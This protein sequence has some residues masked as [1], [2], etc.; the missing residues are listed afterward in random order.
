MTNRP[1]ILLMATMKQKLAFSKLAGKVGKSVGSAM[2]ESGYTA[3]TSNTPKKL[4]ESKGFQELLHLYA[5]NDLLVRVGLDALSATKQDPY[6]GEVSPDYAT[7]Y[8]YWRDF[9]KFHDNYPVSKTT[10][11]GTDTPIQIVVVDGTTHPDI[12]IVDSNAKGTTTPP[13]T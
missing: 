6:T 10:I 2:R 1:S 5:P 11:G 3:I 9:N 8:A 12:V 4:T 7:R 13:T